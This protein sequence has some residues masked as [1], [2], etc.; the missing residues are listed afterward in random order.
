MQFAPSTSSTPKNVVTAAGPSASISHGSK[1]TFACLPVRFV[2][3]ISIA[4]MVHGQHR[5]FIANATTD[6]HKQRDAR[7]VAA[8][9]AFQSII[10]TGTGHR[11]AP[12]APS[13]RKRVCTCITNVCMCSTLCVYAH[14][15]SLKVYG[16]NHVRKHCLLSKRSPHAPCRR[17]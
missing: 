1:W 5:A 7:I 14:T 16:C 15:S 4:A 3:E 9:W 10:R 2:R 17:R 8:L 6:S 13:A 12:P 11:T